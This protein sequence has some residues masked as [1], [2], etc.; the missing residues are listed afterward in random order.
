MPWIMIINAIILQGQNIYMKLDLGL[1]YS[2]YGK[3]RKN[4]HITFSLTPFGAELSGTLF[5]VDILATFS[6]SF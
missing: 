4:I 1:H 5:S 6:S 2:K 3:R